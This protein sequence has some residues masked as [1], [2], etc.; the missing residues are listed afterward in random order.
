[1]IF[2][3]RFKSKRDTPIIIVFL[4]QRRMIY[5]NGVGII[6]SLQRAKNYTIILFL[7]L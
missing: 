7:P 1:M 3:I 2:E 4:Y 5:T 6:Y